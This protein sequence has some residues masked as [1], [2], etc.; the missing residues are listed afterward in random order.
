MAEIFEAFPDK[1]TAADG[2]EILIKNPERGSLAKRLLHLIASEDSDGKRSNFEIANKIAWLP[3]IVET[4][5]NAQAKIRDPKSGNPVFVR[6]YQEGAIHSVVVSKDGVFLDSETFDHGLITQF[7]ERYAGRRDSFIVEWEKASRGQQSTQTAS[8]EVSNGDAPYTPAAENNISHTLRNVK[9]NQAGATNRGAFTPSKA[10]REEESFSSAWKS[11]ITLFEGAADASTLV[12]ETAHY[13]F[14]MMRNLVRVGAADERMQ[15]D[16]AKLQGWAE[17]DPEKAKEQYDRYVAEFTPSAWREAPL[18]FDDWRDTAQKERL[19]RAFEAYCLEGKAPTVALEGAF[20]T[21]RR[22]L[23]HVYHEVKA[24]GVN[25]TAEV[26]SVFDGMLATDAAL[27][28]QSLLREAAAAIN[29]ELLG[30]SQPEVRTFRELIAKANNQAIQKLTAKKHAQLSRLRPL[31]RREATELMNSDPVYNAWRAIQR[32]GGIDYVELEA[33]CGEHLAQALRSKGLTTNPGRKSR[34]KIDKKTGEV[35]RP[36]GYYSA[37]SGK[38]VQL[39]RGKES[40][41]A[42]ATGKSGRG[43]SF[44]K[45]AQT[46]FFTTTTVSFQSR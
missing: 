30:L 22:L 12:H 23:L 7:A 41:C 16:F 29:K 26:R 13:A 18:P 14:E 4:L 31:W 9:L 6:S 28:Q 5:E 17:I 25:L 8:T 15:S 33:I 36:A 1:V 42:A 38:E 40:L 43:S 46:R 2:S 3:R 45:L 34:E 20:A 37:K 39:R 44:T 32:E 35:I 10:M 21:L 24:L 11:T 27:Q 19:A